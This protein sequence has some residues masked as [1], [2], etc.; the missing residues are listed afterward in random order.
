MGGKRPE[1]AATKP[2]KRGLYQP[3]KEHASVGSS[4]PLPGQKKRGGGKVPTTKRT[5]RCPDDIWDELG[6]AAAYETDIWARTESAREFTITDMLIGFIK[7]GLEAYWAE[8]EAAGL[9]EPKNRERFK[10]N[11]R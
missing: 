6:E 3:R 4:F 5:F 9:P 8:R 11:R 7:D 2:R 10:R 1:A